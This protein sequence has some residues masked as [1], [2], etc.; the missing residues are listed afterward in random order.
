MQVLSFEWLPFYL[1]YLLKAITAS[2]Q[3]KPWACQTLLAG[4]FLTLTGLCDWYFVLYLFFFTGL[5]VLWQFLPGH[6][7]ATIQIENPKSKIFPAPADHRWGSD[8]VFAQS[9]PDPNG[10]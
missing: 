3:G 9:S 6:R 4:L 8:V 7:G 5:L 1:L 2:Q 10:A